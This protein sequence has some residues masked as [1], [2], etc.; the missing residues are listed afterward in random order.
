[1]KQRGRQ[2][3]G[4]GGGGGGG[5]GAAENKTTDRAATRWGWGRKFPCYYFVPHLPLRRVPLP[6]AVGHLNL[7]LRQGAYLSPFVG[8]VGDVHITEARSEDQAAIA[9]AAARASARSHGP[10]R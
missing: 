2:C 7:L 8:Q 1:L 10:L 9:V 5:G 3:F 4:G 6:L